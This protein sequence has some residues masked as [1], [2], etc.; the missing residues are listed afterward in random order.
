MAP[1]DLT[2]WIKR[3]VHGLFGNQDANLSP[4]DMDKTEAAPK[5]GG[6]NNEFYP[7]R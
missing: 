5:S 2:A 7:L 1:I 4:D 3:P 6:E